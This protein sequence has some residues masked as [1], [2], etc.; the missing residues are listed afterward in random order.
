MNL[1]AYPKLT[2]LS[3]SRPYTAGHT[4][5]SAFSSDPFYFRVC[6]RCGSSPCSSCWLS[7]LPSP[8][9]RPCLAAS[10]EVITEAI[11]GVTTGVTTEVTMEGIT[12]IMAD[13]A[14]VVAASEQGIS[15]FRLP[16]WQI[17]LF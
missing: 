5:S 4:Y 11:T 2:A 13:L 9:P 1:C 3:I 8:P 7:P 12:V 14:S 6:C 17:K 16:T 15:D 10:A